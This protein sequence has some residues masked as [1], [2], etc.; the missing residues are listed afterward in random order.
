MFELIRRR[1]HKLAL[2]PTLS[3]IAFCG[4][5]GIPLLGGAESYRPQVQNCG[6]VG[7]GSPSKYVC[8]A[9]ADQSY[10]STEGKTYTT[11][12]LAKIRTGDK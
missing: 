5:A 8:D 1:L 7:I 9:R 6:V 2:I 3:A 12:E 10:F 11:F 4:C